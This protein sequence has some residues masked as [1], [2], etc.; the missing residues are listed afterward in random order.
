MALLD[1]YDSSGKT[2]YVSCD[3]LKIGLYV[4][5][6]LP[7]FSHPFTLN[8]F[9]IGSDEQILLLQSLGVQRFRYDP[10]LSRGDTS[11]MTAPMSAIESTSG[12]HD[13]TEG[14][15]TAELRDKHNRTLIEYRIRFEHAEKAFLKST[16][17]L[18]DFNRELAS[19]PGPAVGKAEAFIDQMITALDR[20]SEIALQVM[21]EKYNSAESYSHGLNV[22][23]LCMLLSRSL[24]MRPEQA[25]DLGL[26][27]LMHDIGKS[28]IPD[29][30]LRKRPDEYTKPER[31]LC[32]MHCEFGVRTG[33]SLGLS[34]E[35]LTILLQHHEMADGTGYPR[36]LKL[37]DMSLPSRIVGLVNHYDNLCNPVDPAQAMT[38]HEALSLMFGQRR[39][40]FDD[41]VLQQMIRC[42]GV[43]PPG[44]IVTL[45]NG[46]TGMVVSVTPSRP[47][48]PVVMIYAAEVP[49]EQ[50]ILLDLAVDS[51][52]SI[53]KANDPRLLPPAVSAY[54]CPR[55][56]MT[57]FFDNNTPIDREME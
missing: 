25:R 37:G 24:N 46:A 2:L 45:S 53:E 41:S 55:R 28:E 52:I 9:R 40:K 10:Q 15:V 49:K 27:A 8:S 47:L 43:Y 23:V 38:P 14:D 34:R 17:M 42:L 29:R 22:T 12:M 1:D 57:Y 11:P 50:A 21:S 20:H 51:D 33:K 5:I 3:E 36:G 26:G 54:L 16:R 56:R 6:D 13:K 31:D 32:A 35:V 7:W 19:R 44:T 48:R 18:R 30:V 39:S 4:F